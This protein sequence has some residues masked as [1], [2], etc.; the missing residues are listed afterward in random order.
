MDAIVL[1]PG[2]G[3]RHAMGDAWVDI[4]AGGQQTAGSFYCG[5]VVIQPGFPGPPPHVHDRLHDMFYVLEGS[6]TM[7]LGDE[8]RAVGAGTFVCVPPGV[9]HTFSNPGAAPV[10]F[11]NFN[12][13]AGWEGYM[14]DLAA[15]AAGGRQLTTQEIGEIAARNDFRP[16]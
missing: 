6:L 5:E 12:T 11:L 15:A 1:G 8:E 16:V 10:R 14:R 4:K 7:R 2:D 9:V 13:P 3:E